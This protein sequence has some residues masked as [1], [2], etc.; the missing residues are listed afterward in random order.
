MDT[1]PFGTVFM[2]AEKSPKRQ[3]PGGRISKVILTKIVSPGE[4]RELIAVEERD[5]RGIVV[6]LLEGY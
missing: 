3:S 2:V 1:F 6:F 4:G 5:H